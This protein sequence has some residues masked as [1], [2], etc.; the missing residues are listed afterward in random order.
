MRP[1][2]ILEEL[3]CFLIAPLGVFLFLPEAGGPERQAEKD[4]GGKQLS[5]R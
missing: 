4:E 3:L 2:R 5:H 1:R